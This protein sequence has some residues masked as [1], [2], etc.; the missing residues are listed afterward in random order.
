MT[1]VNED[2]DTQNNISLTIE[3]SQSTQFK[4]FGKTEW[5]K[6]EK[7]YDDPITNSILEA[8]RKLGN[9]KLS[10][11]ELKSNLKTCGDEIYLEIRPLLIEHGIIDKSDKIAIKE[12]VEIK[13]KKSKKITGKL[14]KDE[15]IKKNIMSTVLKNL[16]DTLKTFSG[17]LYNVVYGFNS[18]YA[19]IKL[20]T[21]IYAINFWLKSS[22]PNFAQCYELVL[23]IR[24]TLNNI[25]NLEG[26]S[27]IA[28]NDLKKA[29]MRLLKY[30]D[31]KY[32]TMFEK[33]PRLCLMTAYDTVFPSMSIKPYESQTKL[34]NEIKK[35]N[36]GLYY[37]K[38]MINTGK[39]SVI[40]ALSEH[41]NVLRMLQK[42]NGNKSSTQ[43]IFACSVEPVRH[44]VCRMAYNQKI[45]FGIGVIDN[46]NVKVI[47]NY[48][49]KSDDNRILIVA[50]LDATIELLNKSQDYILFVDEPTVGAD[51]PNHPITNAV[52]KVFALAPETTIMCSAT[53]PELHEIQLLTSYFQEKHKNSEIISI[54]SKESLIGCEVINFDGST[55]APHNYCAS[56]DELQLIVNNLKEKPFIDRLYT[57]P[58]VYKL[59]QRMLDNGIDDVIDLETY[60]ENVETLS[61]TNIQKAAIEILEK[62]ISFGDDELIVKI[63]KPLGKIVIDENAEVK[64]TKN[65]EED[66]NE[67]ENGF[68]WNDNNEDNKDVKKTN[69]DEI[70]EYNLDKIFTEEAYR[71]IG[72]C[73]ITVDDPL[74]FAFEKSRDL[75]KDCE[76]AS[77]IINKYTTFID[78]FNQSLSRLESIK[79]ED[80][81]S[82]KEQEMKNECKPL[83]NFPPTLRINTLEHFMHFVPQLQKKIDKKM[84]QYDFSLEN[85]PLTFNV[86]DWVMLLLFAG[87]GIYAPH[88][89][90]L[91]DAYL[92]HVLNMTA[93]GKLAF[94]ISDDNIC[95]GANYPFSHVNIDDD[96]A[97][98]HSIGTI[99][100]LMGRAGRVGQSWVAYAHVGNK[101]SDRIMN[102]IK[103]TESIG[104]TEEA[105]NINLAFASVIREIKTLKK[106]HLKMYDNILQLNEIKKN[107]IIKLSEVKPQQKMHKSEK[108]DKSDKSEK[109][110]K[111]GQSDQK[112][113]E[114]TESWETMLDIQTSMMQGQYVD[115]F[116]IIGEIKKNE[117]DIS[118]NKQ[119]QKLMEIDYPLKTSGNKKTFPTD[120]INHK[121]QDVKKEK[122][123]EKDPEQNQC[124]IQFNYKNQIT[125]QQNT[126]PQFGNGE[127]RPQFNRDQRPQ[128]GNGEPRPQFN[129]DQRPQF[130]KDQ[131]PQFDNGEP[132]PQFNR[133]QRSQFGNGEPRPQFGNGEPRPQFNREQGSQFNREPGSQF[134]R[135]PR[136]QFGNGEPR[137][138][139][140][141]EPRQQFGNGEPRQQFNREPR[142]F[143]EE[144]PIHYRE[145]R[146]LQYKNP[147]S[148]SDNDQNWRTKS[149]N[150][151]VNETP[152]GTNENKSYVP[153]FK[154]TNDTLPNQRQY[155]NQTNQTNNDQSQ[156]SGWT[157]VSR[158]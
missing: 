72:K 81:R 143:R 50:D 77:K 130:N 96:L 102:Y 78:K 9:E 104:I 49:C 98:K 106:N 142:Q 43:L 118:K 76:S 147:D 94:L 21:F 11:S 92:E 54:C 47:N 146:P 36:R 112:I 10:L 108:M 40:I 46:D 123:K 34:L 31:F 70:M 158:K 45:P 20:V 15:I 42:A 64:P 129:R 90:K 23:G 100:Q 86:P 89:D 60:F 87:I 4:K 119:S 25:R 65:D 153:P 26:I 18:H 128:F 28:C 74:K 30:C 1:T 24:K 120:T 7:M 140:N 79:N 68:T 95:Y 33:Y 29:Y 59:R 13:K 83:L 150:D 157:R 93:D 55:I 58:V 125:L 131:R 66:E 75:L 137:P 39:T 53:L 85:L 88:N 51:Q 101:T 69:N 126:R 16:E 19:E 105:N 56:C 2:F 32:S 139:F 35:R 141:R 91:D 73:L 6:I 136:S 132:R 12:K 109:M 8:M 37:Y 117:I 80:D 154:R 103:G 114:P 148:K 151:N 135:E 57:A 14:T 144:R 5:G 133:D 67:N 17:T 3:G 113:I 155:G 38:A 116:D 62:L 63:C 99:F 71:Y 149:P 27:Q 127:P 52:A 111:I 115:D 152:I 44:Q 61:Q 107:S 22:I 97:N 145:E 138:Q 110:D 48:S 41:V 121:Q 84:F 124:P 122:E 134:N 156:N 82:K